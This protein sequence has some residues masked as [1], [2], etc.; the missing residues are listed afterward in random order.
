MTIRLSLLLC[1][2]LASCS[3][4][5]PSLLDSSANRLLTVERT[6]PR[7]EI[8]TMTANGYLSTG[9]HYIVRDHDGTIWYIYVYS[10]G[11][12]SGRERLLAPPVPKE[13]AIP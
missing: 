1:L 4:D 7:A 2:A 12:I 3:D 9:Y 13:A 8:A 11:T 10:A 6:Y 5:V